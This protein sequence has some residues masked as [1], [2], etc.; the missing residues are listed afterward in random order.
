VCEKSELDLPVNL[1]K[2]RPFNALWSWI[3]GPR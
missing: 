1:L 2:L 3:A